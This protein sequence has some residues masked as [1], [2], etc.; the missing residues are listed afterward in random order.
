MMLCVGLALSLTSVAGAGERSRGGSVGR[1]DVRASTQAD[2]SVARPEVNTPVYERISRDTAKM[3]IGGFETFFHTNGMVLL[4]EMLGQYDS[5]LDWKIAQMTAKG[6]VLI[7][8]DGE[9]ILANNMIAYDSDFVGQSQ[10]VIKTSED[11]MKYVAY[12]QTTINGTDVVTFTDGMIMADQEQPL[13]RTVTT[14]YGP[15][16]API[17][18]DGMIQF[19]N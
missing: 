18:A 6:A 15:D 11:R 10:K 14:V 7:G 4:D 2:T 13:N 1:E 9:K 12:G 8:S 5:I 3:T 19:Q 16:G 17:S